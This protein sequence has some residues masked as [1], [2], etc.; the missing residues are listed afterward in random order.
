MLREELENALRRGGYSE[1][2]IVNGVNGFN[3]H[4]G[5][6]ASYCF[7][8]GLFVTA[9]FASKR[10]FCVDRSQISLV[11]AEAEYPHDVPEFLGSLDLDYDWAAEVIDEFIERATRVAAGKHRYTGSIGWGFD[12]YPLSAE[13][14]EIGQVVPM[15]DSLRASVDMVADFY[16]LVEEQK[17]REEAARKE[18][19]DKA[20]ARFS[21]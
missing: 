19:M 16:K 9:P 20:I 11:R 15:L 1:R 4:R 12:Y 17:S 8:G 5:I 6:A 18:I 13:T 14:D 10:V 7:N 3:Q 2:E 21:Q